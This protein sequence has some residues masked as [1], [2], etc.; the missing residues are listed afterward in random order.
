VSGV[1]Q[2]GAG[3]A[4]F[5][6]GGEAVGVGEDAG[7]VD[8]VCAHGGR[9]AAGRGLSAS[10]RES[11]QDHDGGG[12]RGGA[13]PGESAGGSGDQQ[14]HRGLDRDESPDDRHD[15]LWYSATGVR[16]G[17]VRMP[18]RQ[19]Q[20]HA[21][22]FTVQRVVSALVMRETNPAQSPFRRVAGA[23]FAGVLIAS[24][25]LAGA[26]VHAVLTGGG[27]GDWR[28]GSS[29]IVERESGA[30]YVYRDGRLHPVLNFASALLIV[31]SARTVT[32]PRAALGGVPR[33]VPVG[34]AGAPDSLPE[35]SRLSGPPWTVCSRGAASVLYV[36]SRPGGGLPLGDAGL[37]V[38]TPDGEEYLVWQR[39]RYHV[40]E[41]RV[42][43]AAFGWD[44][45]PVFA[46]APAL[47]NALPAGVDLARIRLNRG[48]PSSA[49]RGARVGQVFVVEYPDGGRQYVVAL[50]DGLAPLTEVEAEL[51]LADP[52]TVAALGQR[53]ASA[54]KPGEYTA[55]RRTTGFGAGAVAPGSAAALPATRPKL[56]RASGSVCAEVADPRGVVEIRVDA[57]VPGDTAVV[58][59]PGR[60]AV[61]E[62]VASPSAPHGALSLV[63]D[64][65]V[66]YPLPSVDVLPALGYAGVVPVRI[67]A[68][69]VAVLPV[70]RAL[71]PAAAL[72]PA[73]P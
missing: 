29:V 32:V 60:G 69:V 63:N 8:V 57:E 15:G 5:E 71:D 67:P 35:R 24:L 16:V 31:G 23:A 36:G 20:L 43:L 40:R 64:L 10:T 62:A 47:V 13:Q 49:V 48:A 9:G 2:E 54:L 3:V 65:G 68:E 46:V 25:L 70:G 22:Q 6:D 52:D 72:T 56:A 44:G 50:A 53:T 73:V 12:G 17:E 51:L 7:A 11:H 14:S 37:L 27:G 26:A 45:Q 30:R 4:E 66:R 21:H 59:A 18:S 28:D 19:D 41:P 39:H 1:D 42:V 38:A 34:I 61:V 55:A 58:V 33:G